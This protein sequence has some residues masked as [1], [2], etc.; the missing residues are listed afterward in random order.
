MLGPL[1]YVDEEITVERQV[2][3]DKYCKD[4]L[5]LPRYLAESKLVQKQLFGIHEG[6]IELDYDPRIKYGEKASVLH[7]DLSI[8]MQP[9]NTSSI[10]HPTVS[11][12]PELPSHQTLPEPQQLV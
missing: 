12:P 8:S 3:L 5:N 6:D 1:T 2:D 4:L 11:L 9:S 7:Q 10:I